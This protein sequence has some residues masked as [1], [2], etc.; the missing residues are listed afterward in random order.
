ML[1]L[2]GWLR[3]V[4]VTAQLIVHPAPAP[5]SGSVPLPTDSSVLLPRIALAALGRGRSTFEVRGLDGAVDALLAALE[6]LG[7]HVERPSGSDQGI[8]AVRGV[9]LS[10]FVRVAEPLDLR[11]ESHAAAL[12]LSHVVGRVHDTEI[13]VDE[14][15]ADLLLPALSAIAAIE[16][17]KLDDA[18]GGVAIRALAGSRPEPLAV[19][20]LGLVPWVKQAL[21]LV[22]LRATGP[23]EVSEQLASPDHLERALFRSRMPID[24]TS[25]YVRVHPPR[26]DD[27]LAPSTCDHVGSAQ[28]ALWLAACAAHV[29]GSRITV[30]DVSTSTFGADVA[31][32]ARFMGLDVTLEARGERQGEPIGEITFASGSPGAAVGERAAVLAAWS[33]ERAPVLSGELVVR[34]GDGVLALLAGL[35]TGSEVVTV[36]DY[37]PSA[38]GGDPRILGRVAGLF[39]SSGLSLAVEEAGLV[40]G[41][42]GRRGQLGFGSRE[43]LI[44]TTGGD[45]R[46]ALTAATLAL[47]ARA[48]S[49]IDDVDCLRRAFPRFVGTM[50]ALGARFDVAVE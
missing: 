43:P 23:S 3:A 38:R 7:A 32:A 28:A 11:G 48:V 16:T 42:P 4:S 1:S 20:T 49:R 30:R 29:P 5:L 37:V 17:W 31:R 27:A 50:R 13:W 39:E 26:D 15:V 22:G 33:K 41:G 6:L 10:G 47:G 8:L 44:T 21:L 14:V 19:E 18:E 34:L 45:A 35:G 40:V 46:L 25:T 24:V 36:S 9:G 2:D 12:V